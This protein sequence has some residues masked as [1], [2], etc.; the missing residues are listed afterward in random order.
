MKF[1]KLC[2]RSLVVMAPSLMGLGT[3][4]MSK[5]RVMLFHVLGFS[6]LLLLT[7]YLTQPCLCS[8][9][10]V[11]FP[12]FVHHS[13]SHQQV[14]N[15]TSKQLSLRCL[16]KLAFSAASARF[17]H[18]CHSTRPLLRRFPVPCRLPR[19]LISTLTRK[20]SRRTRTAMVLATA[21]RTC[22]RLR[23]TSPS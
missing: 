18:N 4:R 23:R 1:V 20:S 22:L 7:L 19:L 16:L 12:T 8:I 5:P 13:H 11:R 9:I 17:R 21:R 15:W 6:A 14:G 3:Y 2:R 10:Q